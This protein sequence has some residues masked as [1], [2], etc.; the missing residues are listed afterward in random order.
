MVQTKICIP[1]VYILYLSELFR[2][3]LQRFHYVCNRL[4][5]EMEVSVH[6]VD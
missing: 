5:S 3:N 6:D 1:A 2:V 4:C